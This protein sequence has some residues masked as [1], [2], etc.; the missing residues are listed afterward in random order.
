MTIFARDGF[1]AASTR[2]IATA[3]AVNQALINY[4]FATKQGLY[5]AVFASIAEQIDARIGPL[6]SAIESAPVGDP[7]DARVR[8]FEHL[9][10][11]VG[12]LLRLMALDASTAWAQLILREQQAPTRA[13]ALLY[14]GF[15]GR[16]FALLTHLVL[17]LAPDRDAQQARLLVVTIIGQVMVFRAARAGVLRQLGWSQIGPD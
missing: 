15:M 2:A 6:L 9:M 12:G 11:L 4:H 1:H 13:F 16:V 7:A 8:A 3:A 14:D 5:L 17:Q 10:Q